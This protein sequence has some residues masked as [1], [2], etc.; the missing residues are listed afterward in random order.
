MSLG[1][2]DTQAKNFE[3][4]NYIEHYDSLIANVRQANPDVAILLTTTTDNFIRRRTANK[5]PVL[6]KDAML[7]LMEKQKVAVWDLYSVMGG[8]KSMLKW[9]KA[10]L[11]AKDR[12]HFS[13]KGYTILGNLMAEALL[14]SYHYN[15]KK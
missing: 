13:P 5:R 12:V 1:V 2:N 8:Y 7:E 9:V 6:A 14:K 11:G 10:G 3:K 4:D 15:I